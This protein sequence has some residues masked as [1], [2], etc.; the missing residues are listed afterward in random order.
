MPHNKNRDSKNQ[1]RNLEILKHLQK[2]IV[3]LG[4]MGTGKTTIG[5]AIAKILG[6]EFLDTDKKI[7]EKAGLTTPEIFSQFGEKKFRE[8]EAKIITELLNQDKKRVIATGGGAV[9]NTESLAY[10]K[11]KTLSVWLNTDLENL[12]KRV[13]KNKNRPL[14][15]TENPKKTLKNLMDDRKHFYEQADIHVQMKQ[16]CIISAADHV[17]EHL[18]MYLKDK[19]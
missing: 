16:D 3:M 13:S 10:I 4:M 1:D 12:Y 19:I 6:L 5:R 2:P 15:Q 17:L 8:V 14:L 9:V 18:H 11:N 7:E